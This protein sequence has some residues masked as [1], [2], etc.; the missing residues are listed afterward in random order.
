MATVGMLRA[1]CEGFGP[2]AAFAAGLPLSEPAHAAA[3]RSSKRGRVNDP[4]IRGRGCRS[5]SSVGV[6]SV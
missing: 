3:S 4:K 1:D 6:A 2:E 5:K